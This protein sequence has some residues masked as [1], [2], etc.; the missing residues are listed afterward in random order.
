M[1]IIII[2]IIFPIKEMSGSTAIRTM[3]VTSFH[4]AI[5]PRSFD[6]KEWLTGPE[7]GHAPVD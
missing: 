3:L 1:L 6:G 4:G 2:T 5:F 7:A